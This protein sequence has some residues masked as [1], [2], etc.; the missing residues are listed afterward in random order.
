MQD[1]SYVILRLDKSRDDSWAVIGLPSGAIANSQD[2]QLL[3]RLDRGG[4]QRLADDL[5]DLRPRAESDGASSGLDLS[6]GSNL[7]TF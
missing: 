6:G 5:N 4:A 2:G 1:H 7:R 3:M